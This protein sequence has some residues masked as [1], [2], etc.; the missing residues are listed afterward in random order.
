MRGICSGTQFILTK[1]F[2]AQDIGKFSLEKESEKS[3]ET[4]EKEGKSLSGKQIT[5]NSGKSQKSQQTQPAQLR[6]DMGSAG[7]LFF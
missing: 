6:V 7:R 1:A 4:E 3:E 5:G 2:V